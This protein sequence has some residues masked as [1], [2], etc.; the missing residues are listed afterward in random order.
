MSVVEWT[1]FWRHCAGDYWS[2]PLRTTSAHGEPTWEWWDD[3]VGRKLT[4]WI[5]I[6]SSKPWFIRVRGP[7]IDEDMDDGEVVDAGALFM[8]LSGDLS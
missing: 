1:E 4:I 8:W 5:D 2:E 7:R 6:A 3:E